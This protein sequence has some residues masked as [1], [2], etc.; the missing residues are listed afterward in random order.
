MALSNGQSLESF[1]TSEFAGILVTA[2]DPESFPQEGISPVISAWQAGTPL[3]LDDAAATWAGMFHAANPISSESQILK[4][5]AASRGFLTG[6]VDSEMGL[7]LLPITVESRLM[8]GNRWG[9]LFSLAYNHPGYVAVGLNQ[10]AALE[11]NQDGAKVIG[12][13][14]VI[15]LDLR[16][17]V[18]DSGQNQAFVIANGLLDV[19]A[20]GESLRPDINNLSS[21]PAQASTPILVTATSTPLPTATITPSPTVTLTPTPTRRPTRTPRPPRPTATPPQ[22]PPPSNPNMNQ[23]MITFGTLIIIII[24]FGLLLNRRRFG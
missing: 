4:G 17:A 24:I 19:F 8:L 21:I 23:L 5:P 7:G 14:T 15:T 13:R 11:I 20:P 2:P 1:E 16:S 9:R 3:L 12:D 18:L 22:V 10:G 6:Q